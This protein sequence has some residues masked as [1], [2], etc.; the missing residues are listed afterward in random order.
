[1]RGCNDT[2]KN[3]CMLNMTDKRKNTCPSAD[4]IS[5]ISFSGVP[6]LFFG[7]IIKEVGKDRFSIVSH[8]EILSRSAE[9]E[10][11]RWKA[12]NR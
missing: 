12:E 8:F 5:F 11:S 3:T 9:G 1:M 4:S 2:R 7:V 6:S 10:Q